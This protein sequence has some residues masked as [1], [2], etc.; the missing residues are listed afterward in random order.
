MTQNILGIYIAMMVITL[1]EYFDNV[2]VCKTV[3]MVLFHDLV[4]IYDGDTF[5]YDEKENIGK[6]E[7]EEESAKKL[8]SLLPSDQAKEY[9]ELWYEFEK[10]A[11]NEAVFAVIIDRLQLMMMN[12]YTK[13]KMWRKK[14]VTLDKLLKREKPIFDKAPNEIKDYFNSLINE[15]VEKDYFYVI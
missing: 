2:D 6:E 3:K 8:F 9:I 12:F 10:M 13:G 4:E 5:A 7:R 15:A 1:S 14:K 11:T